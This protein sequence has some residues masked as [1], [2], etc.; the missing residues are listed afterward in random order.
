MDLDEM[1]GGNTSRSLLTGVVD[2][3]IQHYAVLQFEGVGC[4]GAASD[5]LA[6]GAFQATVP[7]DLMNRGECSHRRD[8]TVV[9]WNKA[10]K[11]QR[12]ILA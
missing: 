8:L 4:L 9:A 2:R 10:V 7:P 5:R 11:Q 3:R 6:T 12:E 1:L